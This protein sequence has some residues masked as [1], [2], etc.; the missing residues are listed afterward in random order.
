MFNHVAEDVGDIGDG[1]DGGVPG[2]NDVHQANDVCFTFLKPHLMSSFHS[3]P[4]VT[5]VC[6]AFWS[7]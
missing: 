4:S 6:S 2:S 3:L 5:A 1:G 7:L